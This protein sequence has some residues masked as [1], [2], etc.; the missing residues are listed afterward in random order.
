MRM[1]NGFDCR[2]DRWSVE[3]DHR[4]GLQRC[5]LAVLFLIAGAGF[6]AESPKPPAPAKP[7]SRWVEIE[8]AT[9]AMALDG[10][11]RLNFSLGEAA[12][13]KALGLV[14][15]LRHT[16]ETD[17]Y[18][19]ARSAWQARGLQSSLVPVGRERLRW[20]AFSGETV[21]F[22]R[23]IIDRAF[24]GAGQA[25]WLIREISNAGHEIRAGD[26]RTWRFQA[27]LP[28]GVDDPALG[29]FSMFTQGALATE[30][31]RLDAL[32]GAPPLL[33]AAYETSGRLLALTVGAS[34]EQR[35]VWDAA[36]QLRSWQRADGQTVRFSYRDGLLVSVAEPNQ[37]ERRLAWAEN[38][39][40]ARGDSRWAA[41][42]H[43]AVDGAT[44]YDYTLSAAGFTLRRRPSDGGTEVIT[45]FNPRRRRVEQRQGKTAMIVTFRGGTA[46]R[47]ALEKIE[48]EAGEVL[49]AYRYDARGQLI[50]VSRQGEPDRVL[51][52]DENG[53]VMALEE[54]F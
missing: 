22:K 54:K 14:P 34:N 28:V 17:A 36:G 32:P 23:A 5:A 50:G 27:G 39:G 8:A 31:R 4:S 25:Q 35:F 19:C 41:P 49:E 6:A 2:A 33:R 12:E 52:Y 18:G 45:I 9:G 3:P 21:E 48:T 38:P 7:V 30:I 40:H 47:G 37:V 20:R 46:G 26:G 43:L 53:R 16:V 51:S 29:T 15:E 1:S 24:S 13:L 44:G 42:V 10:T 11:L